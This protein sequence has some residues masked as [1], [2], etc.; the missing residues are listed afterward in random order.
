MYWKKNLKKNW[1]PKKWKKFWWK[2]LFLSESFWWWLSI[3]CNCGWVWCRFNSYL[4][5]F[6]M[7]GDLL[8]KMHTCFF[9][10]NFRCKFTMKSKNDII[11]GHHLDTRT[12]PAKG[13]TKVTQ[14]LLTYE[15]YIE[16]LVSGNH[17][18]AENNSQHLRDHVLSTFW[19]N[20]NKYD[21]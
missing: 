12:Q 5:F 9:L 8:K 13:N 15:K 14:R 1:F 3:L 19:A 11:S 21:D 16:I 2:N 20:K 6:Q 10:F 18:Q 17:V 4:I 7:R